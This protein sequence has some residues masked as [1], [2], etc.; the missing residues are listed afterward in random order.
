MIKRWYL[1]KLRTEKNLSIHHLSDL[2]NISTRI[3]WDME[4]RPQYNACIR[5]IQT[6]ATFFEVK[7]NELIIDV[8]ELN[9]Q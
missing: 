3:I 1:I 2:T 5:T 7:I 4:N 8:S 6:I 9:N